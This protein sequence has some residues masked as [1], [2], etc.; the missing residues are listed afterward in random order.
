VVVEANGSV[1]MSRPSN[2]AH[3]CHAAVLAGF[4]LDTEHSKPAGRHGV[5]VERIFTT[6]N[7]ENAEQI[8]LH[9]S[10]AFSAFPVVQR[11]SF[12]RGHRGTENSEKTVELKD[13]IDNDLLT[14]QVIGCAIEVHR[15]LGPGLRESAY[16]QCMATR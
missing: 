5:R 16:E 9:F 4:S 3:R 13:S 1:E 14:Q 11:S 6:E 10:S 8:Q 7:A 15:T 12:L 2:R